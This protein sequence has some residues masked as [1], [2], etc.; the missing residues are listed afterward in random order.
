MCRPEFSSLLQILSSPG[1]TFVPAISSIQAQLLIALF[2]VGC[3][4][5]PAVAAAGS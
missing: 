4:R 3:R 1:E 5:N 2:K